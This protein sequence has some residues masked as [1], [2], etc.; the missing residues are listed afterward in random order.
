MK[1]DFTHSVSTKLPQINHLYQNLFSKGKAL[2]ATLTSQIAE[3]LNLPPAKTNKLCK[4]VEYIHQSSILHDDV[5]DASSFRRGSL[6]IWRR[7][8]MKKAVLAGDYLLAQS[9]TEA[10]ELQNVPLMS[11][12]ADALKKLVQ[13]EWMQN[14]LKNRETWSGLKKVHELKTS[15]LFEWSLRAPFLIAD[16]CHPSFHRRLSHI[17]NM[18]GV[19]FQRADDL[20][21]FDIRNHENKMVF[22]DIEEGCFNSFAVYLSQKKT[23]KFKSLLHGCR[24]LKEVKKLFGEKEFTQALQSF[25]KLNQQI[26]LDCQAEIE[27]LKKDLLQKEQVLIEQLKKWP[28]HL[29]WRK[30]V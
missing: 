19:L 13:G 25:D 23:Q 16:R 14:D 2:R 4:I 15:S 24:S 21:D 10:A 18:I 20:L 29:Y 8:S 30:N 17:G 9:A 5:I 22:K 26:I 12:T 27:G 11:L 7:Y 6:S 1:F 3:G 28:E